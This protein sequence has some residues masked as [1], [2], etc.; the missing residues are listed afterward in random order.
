L[1]DCGCELVDEAG[2]DEELATDEELPDGGSKVLGGT[3]GFIVAEEA[4]CDAALAS[5]EKLDD[6]VSPFSVSRHESASGP[7]GIEIICWA[8]SR[9][10]PSTSGS[11][12][13]GF[14]NCGNTWI[15]L[16]TGYVCHSQGSAIT[17]I[18]RSPFFFRS[19][20]RRGSS[21]L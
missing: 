17:G 15:S 4:V 3:G 7:S 18:K 12:D 2:G 8:S 19:S 20:S 6:M 13:R 14:P 5:G 21:S 1:P 11:D 10:A 16:I 9:N